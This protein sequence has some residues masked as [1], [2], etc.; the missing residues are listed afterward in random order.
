MNFC[1]MYFQIHIIFIL[2]ET[3]DGDTGYPEGD[4]PPLSE[5]GG[6]P[7]SRARS[8]NI[9]QTAPNSLFFT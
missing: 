4:R 9:V 7:S 8:G 2:C 6:D 1:N 5:P 3:P